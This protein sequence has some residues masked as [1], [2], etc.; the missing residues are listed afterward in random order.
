MDLSHMRRIIQAGCWSI[1]YSPDFV[2]QVKKAC[3][4]KPSG[5]VRSACVDELPGVMLESSDPL[6][7]HLQGLCEK[8]GWHHIN[9]VGVQVAHNAKSFR[10]PEPRF[11]ADEKPLRSTFGRFR[12]SDG[13]VQ[14]RRIESGAAYT[15]L[16]NQHGMIGTA[17]PTL[18][19]MFHSAANQHPLEPTKEAERM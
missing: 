4:A 14:W 2:K 19:T 16:M 12:M 3:S 6:L 17:V 10:T 15:Q 7:P 13:S 1:S 8:R 11:S 9:G 18:I 5:A